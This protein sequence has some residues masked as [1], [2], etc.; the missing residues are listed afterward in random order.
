MIEIEKLMNVLPIVFVAILILG[1]VAFIDGKLK[2]HR[3][4]RLFSRGLSIRDRVEQ[5]Q[6]EIVTKSSDKK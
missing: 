3:I 4:T 2:L 1:A 5:I 6:Q